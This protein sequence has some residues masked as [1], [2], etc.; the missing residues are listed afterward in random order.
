MLTEDHALKVFTEIHDLI[1]SHDTELRRSGV[2]YDRVRKCFDLLFEYTWGGVPPETAYHAEEGENNWEWR[3]GVREQYESIFQEVKQELRLACK[4]YHA[5]RQRPLDYT[6]Y[7][8]F[9]VVYRM[10]VDD[11]DMDVI[12]TIAED[13]YLF[14]GSQVNASSTKT[15]IQDKRSDLLRQLHALCV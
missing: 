11:K 13:K 14:L 12:P 10:C 9:M 15:L 5:V 3:H 7:S 2:V 1:S 8:A 6:T 4:D